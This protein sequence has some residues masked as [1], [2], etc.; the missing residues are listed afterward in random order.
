MAH[1]LFNTLQEFKIGAG[2]TGKF[3]SLPALE[4]AL[5]ARSRACRYPS[6]S[7]S[8]RCC[9]TATARR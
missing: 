4:K 1:N 9:A 2:K 7:C 5:G 3:Y 8:N 6:A